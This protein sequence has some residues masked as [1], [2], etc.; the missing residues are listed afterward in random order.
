MH[1]PEMLFANNA[2]TIRKKDS[3]HTFHVEKIAFNEQ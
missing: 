1:L 3:S 2:I